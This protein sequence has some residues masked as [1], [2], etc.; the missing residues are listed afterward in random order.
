MKKILWN[1]LK[2]TYWWESHTLL[3]WY[4][5]VVGWISGYSYW[6][7]AHTSVHHL[8][9]SEDP[10]STNEL[11]R[12]Y[13]SF[14]CV[15]RKRILIHKWIKSDGIIDENLTN[16]MLTKL[17]EEKISYWNGLINS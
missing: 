5:W 3:I 1:K 6:F 15:P 17:W 9:Y 13:F 16:L 2:F 10:L 11:I 7:V 14:N 4:L 8:C 12:F